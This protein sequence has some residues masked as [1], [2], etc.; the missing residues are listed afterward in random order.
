M[1]ITL[2]IEFQDNVLETLNFLASAL[3][4]AN[5]M[6]NT[7]KALEDIRPK[8]E[9]VEQVEEETKEPEQVVEKTAS[10]FTREDVRAEFVRK[11]ST[12]NREKLKEILDRYEA[13]NIS[14]LDESHFESVMSDLGEL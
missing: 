9:E 2:K 1:Q 10:S 11:N 7:V 4:H 3:A 13:K 5:G 14:T 8:T 12:A 6:K